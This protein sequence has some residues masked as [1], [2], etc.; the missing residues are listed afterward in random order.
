MDAIGMLLMIS[1][2]WRTRS[3]FST[4]PRFFWC[5]CF[6]SVI[7]SDQAMFRRCCSSLV[8]KCQVDEHVFLS[9][10]SLKRREN[11][12]RLQMSQHYLQFCLFLITGTRT[13]RSV[14]TRRVTR[15]RKTPNNEISDDRAHFS[16]R[17]RI[18]ERT[19]DRA[20]EL[21]QCSGLSNRHGSCFLRH[22]VR[23]T[24]CRSIEVQI[25]RQRSSFV[26]REQHL[27]RW[28]PPIPVDHWAPNVINATTRAPAC[29]QPPC[30]SSS[31]FCPPYVSCVSNENS[32]DDRSLSSRKIVSI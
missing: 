7:Q 9:S 14:I 15:E 2:H 19:D 6:F 21:R 32:N 13:L 24:S 4:G 22:S 25:D 10:T 8:R 12:D 20:D 28:N 26:E 31:P 23:S 18:G 1:L 27:T 16:V 11:I 30:N 5:K 3:R 17:L 29:P